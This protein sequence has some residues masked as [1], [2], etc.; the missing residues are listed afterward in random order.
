MHIVID[1]RDAVG[2]P[3]DDDVHALSLPVC[4]DMRRPTQP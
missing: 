3:V 2:S 1:Q 4:G